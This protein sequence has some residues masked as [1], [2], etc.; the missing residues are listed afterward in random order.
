MIQ[1]ISL[2]ASPSLAKN[3]MP[4]KFRITDGAGNLY[5]AQPG[6]AT[7]ECNNGTFLPGDSVTLSWTDE[8]GLD[9]SI[10]FSAVASPAS[11]VQV[12]GTPL[13]LADYEEIAAKIQAHYRIAPVFT[14]SVV[15]NSATNY[16]I[17]ATA[18]NATYDYEVA[19]DNSGLSG[20]TAITA[21]A[22]VADNSPDNLQMLFEVYFEASYNSGDYTQIA[23][24]RGFP[25]A[26]GEVV[27]DV[28]HILWRQM[29]GDRP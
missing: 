26:N 21:T 3:P 18:K 16:S 19:W 20:T 13:V 10:S 15:Q 25:D 14:I 24:M 6:T 11:I 4:W 1:L 8:D 2:P 7:L 12:P 28:S 23:T 22:P 29:L 17:V 5:G 9:Q 27:F